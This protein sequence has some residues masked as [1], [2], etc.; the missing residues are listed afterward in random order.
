VPDKASK[1]RLRC[2]LDRSAGISPA[3]Q[4]GDTPTLLWRKSPPLLA[5]PKDR[6]VCSRRW[7]FSKNS[8]VSR[9]S[10]VRSRR[11]FHCPV[12]A[13]KDLWQLLYEAK[14]GDFYDFKIGVSAPL[15]AT[16]AALKASNAK[17]RREFDAEILTRLVALNAE[18][19]EEEKNGKVRWLRPDYQT[20]NAKS[21]I[22]NEQS[23]LA[24][25]VGE[26]PA[27]IINPSLKVVAKLPWPKS[28]TERV[29]AIESALKSSP[30]TPAQLAKRFSRA[31][32]EDVAEILETLAT[33]GRITKSG[34]VY[35]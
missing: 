10:H 22:G 26:Q 34:D 9:R 20:R 24:L 6:H 2:E 21:G 35:A 28:L 11:N 27:N 19:A 12:V 18:R 15:S 30:G 3:S 7:M 1:R 32:E 17:F 8:V 13:S 33:L 29:Q 31:K 25:P 23:K 14:N 5:T 4:A 16:P